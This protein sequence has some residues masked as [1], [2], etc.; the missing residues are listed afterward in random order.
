MTAPI[1]E[2]MARRWFFKHLTIASLIG[3]AGAELW[4][5]GYAVPRIEKRDA[6]YQNMGVDWVRIVE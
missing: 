3:F 2:G 4:W 5:R 1:I 6:Y